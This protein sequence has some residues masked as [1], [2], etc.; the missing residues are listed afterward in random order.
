MQKLS[1]LIISEKNH[2]IVKRNLKIYEMLYEL[3]H[4]GVVD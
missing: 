4:S 1:D 2:A 3:F